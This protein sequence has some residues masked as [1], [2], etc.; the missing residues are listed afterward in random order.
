MPFG[1]PSPSHQ[2]VTHMHVHMLLHDLYLYLNLYLVPAA[3]QVLHW[4]SSAIM[5]LTHDSAE[6]SKLAIEA[7]AI[8]AL[9][10]ERRSAH[11]HPSLSAKIELARKWLDLQ[12]MGD[13]DEAAGGGGA[14]DKRSKAERVLAGLVWEHAS[15]D[16]DEIREAMALAA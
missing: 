7:G 4:G 1:S 11:M 16:L 6:R 10:A 12:P 3:H 8:E 13:G 9:S 2:R 15:S 5:R 14:G